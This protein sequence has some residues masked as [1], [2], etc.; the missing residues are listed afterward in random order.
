[1][2]FVLQGDLA[3]GNVAINL[4]KEMKISPDGTLKSVSRGAALKTETK[5]YTVVVTS[6]NVNGT[7]R[8]FLQESDHKEAL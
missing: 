4:I 3:M 8:R 7:S 2:D 1:M 6:S 5:A